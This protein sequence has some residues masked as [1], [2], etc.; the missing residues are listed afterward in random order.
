MAK[1]LLSLFVFLI[2]IS[3]YSFDNISLTGP[4][5]GPSGDWGID[6]F[7]TT[8]DGITYTL[9]NHTFVSGEMKFRRNSN[10][11]FAYGYATAPGFPNG[12]GV[13]PGTNIAVPA[14]TYN[15]TFNATTLAYSF[16]AGVPQFP[17]ISVYGDGTS[18]VDVLLNTTNGVDYVAKSITFSAAWVKFRRDNGWAQNWGA[19]GFP[20]GTGTQN[21]PDIPMP[22]G[23]YNI[24]F[25]FT[26]GAYSF[27]PTSVGIIG[28][29][30]PSGS[31]DVDAVMNTTDAIHYTLTNVTI[32]GGGFKVRDNASWA[33]QFGAAG[34]A[35]SNPFPQGSMV[36]NGA[37]M[38]SVSGT[39]N[40]S[41]N[42]TT[43]EYNFGPALAVE[44]SAKKAF[45]VAPN[46][47]NGDWTISADAAIGSVSVFDI[48]G[49]LVKSQTSDENTMTID[50][51]GLSNGLYFAKVVSGSTI[52]TLKLVKK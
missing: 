23:T 51:S 16:T 48:T 52:E 29:G 9:A 34:A 44:T 1:K 47:T 13:V 10:W 49:K 15:V 37:D 33:V 35:G 3:G 5:T 11:D 2:S 40:I 7:M 4:A 20:S 38:A 42:R 21:G 41:F 24:T 6:V 8:T 39:Y 14:G 28:L 17:V 50:A 43:F 26:T 18:S 30:G 22:G 36:Q 46:P 12:T 25:N 45:S 27:T 19:T 32:V 31:W